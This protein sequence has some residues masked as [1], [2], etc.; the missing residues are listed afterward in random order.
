MLFRRCRSVQTFAMSFPIAV[1][2]LDG[3][4]RVIRLRR[5]APR[6]VLRPR[7]GA[8]HLLECPA[9]ADL[10]RGDRLEVLTS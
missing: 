6:R 8:R 9:D 1:A 4:L 3:E 7:A 5:L 2:M 10:R